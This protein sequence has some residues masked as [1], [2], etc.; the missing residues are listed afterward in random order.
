MVK[1][2]E[3]EIISEIK[4]KIKKKE[5]DPWFPSSPPLFCLALL[6]VPDCA[7]WITGL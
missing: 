3:K 7:V 5:E 2:D 4:E 1:K 6:L